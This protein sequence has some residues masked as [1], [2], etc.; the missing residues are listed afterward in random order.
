MDHPVTVTLEGRVNV[1]T[2]APGEHHRL[3]VDRPPVF[4][5]QGG[6]F[7]TR[8]ESGLALVGPW[9]DDEHVIPFI[10][11]AV[12]HAKSLQ[13][14][15]TLLVGLAHPGE[16]ETLAPARA[17]GVIALLDDD[18][19][20]W[21][22]C[23]TDFGGLADI[24]AYLH[25]LNAMHGWR[26]CV[27]AIDGAEDEDAASAVSSFQQEYNETFEGSLTEDG[28]CG[29]QTLGAVFDVIRDELQ[30]WLHKHDLTAEDLARVEWIAAEESLETPTRAGAGLASWTLERAAFEGGEV[31]AQR[32]ADSKVT[33]WDDYEV[34][35]E[36]WSWA[37]GPFTIVTDLPEG[38]VVPREEYTLRSSDGAFDET[39]ALPDDA[40]MEGVQTLRFL[41]VPC[42]K[43][44][45]LTVSVHGASPDTLFTDVPYNKL[46]SFNQE[47]G[48]DQGV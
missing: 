30:R 3:V 9:S 16:P 47:T 32:V 26:C 12:H 10:L 18:R 36:P 14:P 22:A 2:L 48:D 31:S 20:G 15:V 5:S 1:V 37:G 13:D 33:T 24:E 7:T 27:E 17:R 45:T 41:A 46:H 35:P 21:V 43:V 39:L 8:P 42:D 11:G 19:E 38:E 25:Y 40:V 6:P 28:I 44:Y 34:P 4:A 29:K 23:A